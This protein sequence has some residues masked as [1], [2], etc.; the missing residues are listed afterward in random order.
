M[1]KSVLLDTS[2][3]IRF[4][5]INDPLL[6]NADDYFKYFIANNICMIIS[7]ISIAEFCIKGS[8]DQL[9]LMNMQILPFNINHAIRTGEIAGI[10]FDN[11]GTLN[12][13]ERKIIP[14]DTKLFAQADTESSIVY[15]LSS[16][17]ESIKIYN[18]LKEKTSINFQFIDL[19]APISDTFKMLFD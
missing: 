8:I 12:L 1:V 7:T 16:D 19:K 3:F 9:P 4:L 5:N 13:P 6:K 14:N 17:S 10:V 11:K 18:L 2:F 15:Y